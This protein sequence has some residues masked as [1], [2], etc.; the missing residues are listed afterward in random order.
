M[1]AEVDHEERCPSQGITNLGG[2]HAEDCDQRCVA[3]AKH[4][5]IWQLAISAGYHRCE[6]EIVWKE[7]LPV[8]WEPQTFSVTNE[9]T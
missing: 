5:A 7:D 6:C 3:W 1:S 9:K 8:V 4:G 2:T